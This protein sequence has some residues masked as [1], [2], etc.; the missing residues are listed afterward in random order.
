MSLKLWIL[1]DG[2]EQRWVVAYSVAEAC[3]EVN[4]VKGWHRWNCGPRHF[5]E[6]AYND[7]ESAGWEGALAK[8]VGVHE[9]EE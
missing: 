4:A 8:G 2:E 3:R 5:K 9:M 1:G 6:Y 7:P